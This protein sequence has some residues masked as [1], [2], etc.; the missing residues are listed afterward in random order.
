M[1]NGGLSGPPFYCKRFSLSSEQRSLSSQEIVY[2]NAGFAQDRSQ[3]TLGHFTRVMWQGDFPSANR[4]PPDFV[5]AWA[6]TIERIA[7]GASRLATSR[8][9]KPARRPINEC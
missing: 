5:A 6:G 7:K 2:A 3:R 8:Y 4:V 1:D 9:L